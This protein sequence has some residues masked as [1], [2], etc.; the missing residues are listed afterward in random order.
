MPVSRWYFNPK[1]S[2]GRYH[3]ISLKHFNFLFDVA[4]STYSL[5]KVKITLVDVGA[6]GISHHG[7][8]EI[9]ISILIRHTPFNVPR[10]YLSHTIQKFSLS[11]YNEMSRSSDTDLSLFI[12]SKV[13][14]KDINIYKT[15]KFF[16]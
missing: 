7:N 5:W 1:S 9:S 8:L 16:F 15:V 6:W 14:K 2:K 4:T 3:E 10:R 13:R 11:Q 12:A